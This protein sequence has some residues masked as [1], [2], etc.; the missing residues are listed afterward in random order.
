MQITKYVINTHAHRGL[1]SSLNEPFLSVLRFANCM[2]QTV[3]H[4][5]MCVKKTS[6]NIKLGPHNMLCILHV[7]C[8][9]KHMDCSH[10]AEAEAFHFSQPPLP[11][12]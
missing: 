7:K 12:S 10:S 1:A 3:T 6:S 2:V 8:T 9:E 11:R 5:G 4:I